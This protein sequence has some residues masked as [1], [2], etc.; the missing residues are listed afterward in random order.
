MPAPSRA[1]LRAGAVLA[2]LLLTPSAG[3][4]PAAQAAASPPPAATPPPAAELPCAA[5]LQAVRPGSSDPEALLTAA[6]CLRKAEAAGGQAS[7]AEDSARAR[8][9]AL[10]PASPAWYAAQLARLRGSRELSRLQDMAWLAALKDPA[11]PEVWREIAESQTLAGDPFRAAW[12]LLKQAERDSAQGG[13]LQYQLENLVRNLADPPA[14]AFLDSLSARW[15]HTRGVTAEILENLCWGV[16][17]VP[18]AY[19]HTLAWI[20]LRHPGPGMVLD[21]AGRYQTAGWPDFADGV[22]LTA[23]W[24][25]WP[26]PWKPMARALFLRARHQQE[27]WKAVADEAAAA[28][29][30]SLSEEEDWLAASAALRL[31]RPQDALARLDRFESPDGSP[32]GFRAHLLKARAFLAQGRLPEA[33]RLLDALKRSPQRREGA[34]PILFWQG[35]LALQQ[36][37][38][39]AAESLFVL[40][41]AYT[42]GEESQRALEFRYW[43]LLDSGAARIEFLRG[44][45]E[46]PLAD[47]GRLQALDRVPA[48]SPL[49]PH[50]R[51]EKAQI[52]LGNGQRDSARAVLDHAG[53]HSQDRLQALKARALAAWLLEKAPGGRAE[54]LARFEDLLV[55]YQQGVIPEFSRGRI[56]ALK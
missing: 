16:R 9:K 2:V 25:A 49:W 47:E 14:P 56:R 26:N 53:K 39:A 36:R 35:W 27:D 31:G 54:A 43:M 5:P 15:R 46:S 4:A 18:A 37:R 3:P 44:V 34:G 17:H 11:G 52:L 38:D 23:N 6:S 42:G 8:L 19:R 7:P 30:G 55:E 20:A 33:A 32:W 50:A 24:R 51:L 21:R 10:A 12:A 28:P 41:S 40:A 29:K 22:L 1:V 48:G 45:S 13:Y